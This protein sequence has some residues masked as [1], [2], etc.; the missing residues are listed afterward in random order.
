[1]SDCEKLQTSG[2]SKR[3]RKRKDKMKE[4]DDLTGLIL[5]MANKIDPRKMIIIWFV[6]LFLHSEMCAENILKR[7]SGAVNKDLTLTMVGTLWT[8]LFMMI[9]VVIC[10]LVFCR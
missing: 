3:N 1:M 5:N 6:F 9:I 10:E 2:P 7:F 8:S 4:R